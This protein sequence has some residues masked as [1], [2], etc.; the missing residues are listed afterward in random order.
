MDARLKLEAAKRDSAAE[1]TE[2]VEVVETLLLLPLATQ[3][4]A[5]YQGQG[6]QILGCRGAVLAVAQGRTVELLASLRKALQ[7]G[8]TRTS[9][10]CLPMKVR[11][12]HPPKMRF[13][14]LL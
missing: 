13:G 3:L 2:T 12:Q 1:V 14:G 7:L 8:W 4:L 10:H 11:L 5:R 6:H 9:R